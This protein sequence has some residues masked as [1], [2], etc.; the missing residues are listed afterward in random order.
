M[1][2]WEAVWPNLAASAI[3][4]STGLVW[5]QRRIQRLINQQK[6]HLESELKEHRKILGFGDD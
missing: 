4:F 3:T 1:W 6:S 2:F 5:H